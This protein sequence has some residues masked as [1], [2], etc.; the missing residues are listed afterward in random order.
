MKFGPVPSLAYDIIKEARGD[1]G[2]YVFPEPRPQDVIQADKR[3]LQPKRGAD[4]KFL[5]ETDIEC[6]NEAY[7]EIKDLTFEELH[8]MSADEAY[9][10]VE[11]DD[12]MSIESVIKTLKNGESVLDYLN[13][14]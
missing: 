12:D 1:G 14:K 11:Q 10:S 6:L 9:L 8:N 2:W 3:N 7:T 4:T 13:S 5:S